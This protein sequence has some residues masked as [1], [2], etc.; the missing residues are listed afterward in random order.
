MVGLVLIP[1]GEW[2]LVLNENLDDF[3]MV[4]VES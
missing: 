4:T 1:T 3:Q 2:C